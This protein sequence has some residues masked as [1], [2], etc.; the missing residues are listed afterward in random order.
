MAEE[1]HRRTS[2]SMV[3]GVKPDYRTAGL[4]KY[5]SALTAGLLTLL[6][7]AKI[8][9]AVAF[10]VVFAFYLVEVHLLFLFPLLAEGHVKPYRTAVRLCWRVGIFHCITNVIP[11]AVRMLAGLT[12]SHDPF[13]GWHEGCLAIVIW[14]LKVSKNFEYEA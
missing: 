7:F 1:L 13:R 4:I 12:N 10:L 5:G 6:L 14:Y 8:G 9:P 2:N 3:T 11:I